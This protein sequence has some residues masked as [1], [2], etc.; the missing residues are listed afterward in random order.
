MGFFCIIVYQNSNTMEKPS[1][2]P[3]KYTY[4]VVNWEEYN[5]S[6]KKRGKITIWLSPRLLRLWKDIDVRKV[7][8]GEQV[9][10]DELIE[11]CLLI[12]HLYHLP[13][14]QTIGL[15]EDLLLFN[16][17]ENYCV[18]DYSTLCRRAKHLPLSYSQGLRTQKEYACFS[19]FYRLK[20]LWRGGV[21]SEKT[22]CF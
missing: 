22:R 5:N 14:R 3:A 2:S 16:G 17:L 6:L 11:F 15:L 8:V 12:K 19:R 7:R 18:P 21:E 13:L 10:P 4:K 9:Y 20:S 1:K